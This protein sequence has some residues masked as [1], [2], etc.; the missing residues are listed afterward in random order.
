MQSSPKPLTALPRPQEAFAVGET[1][2]CICA[3]NSPPGSLTE[4]HTYTVL[5]YRPP[6]I[7]VAYR[8]PACVSVIGDC[9]K[10]LLFYTHRFAKIGHQLQALPGQG[11]ACVL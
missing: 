5:K 4:G 6:V 10:Q 8:F 9:G 7:G 3:V 1:V 11:F 2:R